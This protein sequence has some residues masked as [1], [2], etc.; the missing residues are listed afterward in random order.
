[1]LSGPELKYTQNQLW[2]LLDMLCHSSFLDFNS[3]KIFLKV[4]GYGLIILQQI[5]QVKLEAPPLNR[6]DLIREIEE[7][8]DLHH[9]NIPLYTAQL[10]LVQNQISN[11]QN[12]DTEQTKEEKRALEDELKQLQSKT[13][14]IDEYDW[15]V[16][17]KV[18][19]QKGQVL[20][21]EEAEC[22]LAFNIFLEQIKELFPLLIDKYKTQERAGTDLE[23][24]DEETIRQYFLEFIGQ[25]CTLNE[26]KGAAILHNFLHLAHKLWHSNQASEHKF[27]TFNIGMTFSLGLFE[28]LKILQSMGIDS[29]D[30]KMRN[31]RQI[32]ALLTSGLISHPIFAQPFTKERYKLFSQPKFRE[33]KFIKKKAFAEEIER[34]LQER[35]ASPIALRMAAL[36][37]SPA[38]A[39]SEQPSPTASSSSS[40]EA[41]TSRTLARI[42]KLGSSPESASPLS[43]RENPAKSRSS[44]D[45]TPGFNLLAMT[46][47]NKPID[48][49]LSSQKSARKSSKK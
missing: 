33:A 16:I 2:L 31:E 10:T 42:L 27:N 17:G 3:P 43:S 4:S 47:V 30:I 32:F 13:T 5:L 41:K 35:R 23:K 26:L 8:L 24:K 38:N 20:N 37:L 19:M 49:P 12:S 25:L 44:Q 39:S 36:V 48:A 34:N 46:A 6:E 40:A 9:R 7:V 1:M 18:A 45:I 22:S 28:G 14:P 21:E 15:A 29:S 11:D